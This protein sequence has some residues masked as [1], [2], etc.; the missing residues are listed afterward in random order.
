[1]TEEWREHI[2]R[3]DEALSTLNRE[4][5]EMNLEIVKLR[6]AI[7]SVQLGFA[8]FK[9]EMTAKLEGYEDVIKHNRKLLWTVILEGF[10][11]LTTLIGL[12]VALIKFLS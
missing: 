5:G 3:I 1:M 4:Q 2:P 9:A 6:E 8:T 7:V 10:L 12:V 11:T